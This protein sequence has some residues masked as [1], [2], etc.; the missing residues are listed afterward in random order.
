MIRGKGYAGRVVIGGLVKLNEAMPGGVG[1]SL[2]PVCGVY[3][4]KFV[5]H[6]GGYSPDTD[7]QLIRNLRI[8]LTQGNEA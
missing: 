8:A 1:S 7:Y 3:L 4:A 5:G 6:M 2:C